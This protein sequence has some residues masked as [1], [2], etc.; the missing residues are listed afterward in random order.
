MG[1][2]GREVLR[3]RGWAPSCWGTGGWYGKMMHSHIW[4]SSL[5]A[6]GGIYSQVLCAHEAID[7]RLLSQLPNVKH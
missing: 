2:G 4:G 3:I 6:L 5:L 1:G 7:D